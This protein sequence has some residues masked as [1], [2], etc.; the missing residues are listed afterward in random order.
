MIVLDLIL[1]PELERNVG[2]THKNITSGLYAELEDSRDNI[3][4]G[5]GIALKLNV[6]LDD[7]VELF[8]QFPS[9]N[10]SKL[11]QFKGAA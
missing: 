10:G 8:M 4:L 9:R 6:K 5:N 2:I 3:I 11:V 7:D 1:E